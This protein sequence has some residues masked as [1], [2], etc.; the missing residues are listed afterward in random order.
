MS[1]A[2]LGSRGNGTRDG[3]DCGSTAPWPLAVTSFFI[4]LDFLKTFEIKN[5]F[6]IIIFFKSKKCFFFSRSNLFEFSRCKRNEG[7]LAGRSAAT[8]KTNAPNRIATSPFY[9]P[10]AV[11]KFAW[12]TALSVNHTH[13]EIFQ[14]VTYLRLYLII[15]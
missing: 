7:S 1:G 15:G 6:I 11:A 8:S 4:S 14:L 9:Y 13:L 5:K 10:D 3:S 12:K 2:G